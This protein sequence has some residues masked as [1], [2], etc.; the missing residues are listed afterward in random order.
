MNKKVIMNK[1]K[2]IEQYAK[3]NDVPIMETTGIEFL[4]DFINKY[5]IKEILEVGSAIGYSAIRMALT[6]EQIQIT[7]I[8]RDKERYLQAKQNIEDMK[9]INR[10]QL[11]HGDA[12]ETTITGKFDMIFIDA[13]KAQYINFFERYEPLLKEGGFMISDNLKFHGFVEHPEQIQSRN[14]RQL[15]RKIK[16]YIDYLK[17]RSDFDTEFIEIGDGVATSRKKTK[18]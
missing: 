14:L 18:E 3:E 6:N 11:L 1:I 8:E 9:L 16:N 2:E 7:T 5:D 10:I 12:L 15:V 17:E 4:C 13:A